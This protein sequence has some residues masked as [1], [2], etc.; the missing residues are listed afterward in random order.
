MTCRDALLSDLRPRLSTLDVSAEPEGRYAAGT[1][2]DIRVS[3]G[4]FNVPVELKRS[5]SP[6]LWTA[7]GD[8]LIPRYARDPGAD[9]RGI[10]LVFWFGSGGLCRN[11]PS[12]RRP[13]NAGELE[14]RLRATLSEDARRSIAICVVDVSGTPHQL[15]Q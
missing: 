14:R 7:V 12:G 3:S 11:P 15:R 13:E 1:M 10:Y 8:Q 4:G 9:G 2:A 6:D 5:M